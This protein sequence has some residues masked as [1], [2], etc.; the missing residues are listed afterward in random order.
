MLLPRRVAKECIAT[1]VAFVDVCDKAHVSSTP[2]VIMSFNRDSFTASPNHRYCN[3]STERGNV[4][5]AR[6]TASVA[7]VSRA[8]YSIAVSLM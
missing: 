2:E 6:H 5:D 8:G 3:S 4:Q 1:T 7:C